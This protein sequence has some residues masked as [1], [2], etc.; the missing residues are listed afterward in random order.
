M[1]GYHLTGNNHTFGGYDYG[2][3]WSYTP[4]KPTLTTGDIDFGKWS[5][6]PHKLPELPSP[7][8]P[9]FINPYNQDIGFNELVN[10]LIN[11]SS[12]DKSDMS[13]EVKTRETDSKIIIEAALPGVG[14]ENIEIAMENQ[15][16]II[17]AKLDDNKVSRNISLKDLSIGYEY[18]PL[19]TYTDGMLSVLLP[20]DQRFTKRQI[21]IS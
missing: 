14:K 8:T 3:D 15:E 7:Y 17:T 18:A 5:N 13:F 19:A 20:K 12:K 2:Q 21:D 16:L 9:T 6:Q 4:Y 11:L 1:P 10:Q